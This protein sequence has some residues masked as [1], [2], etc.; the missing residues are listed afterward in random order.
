MFAKHSWYF[1]NALV[2][3]NYNDFQH[4]VYAAPEY[5]MHFFSNL[6]LGENNVLKNRDLRVDADSK[7]G[8]EKSVALNTN[9]GGQKDELGGQKKWSDCSTLLL[10]NPILHE[11]NCRKC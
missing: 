7:I 11:K 9:E 5:L 2:R 3:A 6:L 8:E 1:R 4:K 10:K